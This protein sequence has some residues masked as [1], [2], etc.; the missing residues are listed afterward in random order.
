MPRSRFEV[1]MRF[2]HFNDN[3]QAPLSSDPGRDRLF[4]IRPLLTFLE[5]SFKSAY[6]P[7]KNVAVDESLMSYKGRLSF[8]QFIPS[9]RAKYG[10]KVYKLCESGTGYTFAFRVYEGKDRDIN[11]PGCPSDIGCSGKIVW[12]LMRPLLNKGYHLYTNN[13]YTSVPL[14]KHLH[15]AATGACGTIRKIRRGLPQKLLRTGLRRG[16]SN[17]LCSENILAIKYNDR[18]DV[19][20]LSTLHP[21]T[22]VTVRER[23]STSDKEKPVCVTEYNK[24]I[25]AVDLADQALQP[26]LVQRKSR[27]WYKKVAIY[28]MQVAAYNSFVLYKKSNGQ[29]SFFKFLEN[30]VENLLFQSPEPTV[31]HES[32]DVRR[33]VEHHFM[34]PVPTTPH[35]R[36]PQKRCRVCSKNGIRRETR[37]Y[38]PSCPS[39]PGLCNY[40][41]FEVFH[42][43]PHY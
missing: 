24:H 5:E 29:D 1:L 16:E 13:F 38:C 30:V 32:E 26:Y 7:E 6:I 37:F 21:D 8:R 23:G 10:I 33:L 18:K 35:K 36:Y 11:P 17:S 39:K 9:K 28:L 40:P 25:G 41:C 42:T 27:T 43:V 31:S 4:K 20:L 34:H 2:L 19:F 12:D 14:Y 22:K 3:H 15:S